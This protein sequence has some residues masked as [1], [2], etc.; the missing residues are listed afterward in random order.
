L[1]GFFLELEK[2][3]EVLCNKGRLDLLKLADIWYRISL[4]LSGRAKFRVKRSCSCGKNAEKNN[5]DVF[6]STK[7]FANLHKNS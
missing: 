4:Q 3:Q 1:P 6:K 2:T 5:F 7:T